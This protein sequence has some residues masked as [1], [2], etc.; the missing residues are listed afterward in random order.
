MN[1]KLILRE[2]RKQNRKVFSSLFRELYEDLVN[3]A[4]GYLFDRDTSE[5]LVQEVF[6]HIWEKADRIEI[7]TS[8]R[9]YLFSMVRNRAIN[10]LKSLKIE[11]SLNLLELNS[12][13][14]AEA[15]TETPSEDDRQFIYGRIRQKL[16][17][18]PQKMQEIVK[19]R[20]IGNYKYSEIAEEL[21]ISVNTVKTQLKR[22]RLKI[23][24]SFVIAIM[25]FLHYFLK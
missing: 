3:Y 22:A 17:A 14:A 12:S 21:G 23:M 10:H 7:R 13:L 18:L 19:L 20:F 25:V 11:D 16:E 2:I 1:Q 15:E 4:R 8:L 5:D 24:E 6:L 9:S